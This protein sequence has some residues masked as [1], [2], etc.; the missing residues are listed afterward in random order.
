MAS[1]V[2]N[3][4]I[5]DLVYCGNCG[6]H[7]PVFHDLAPPEQAIVDEWLRR[8]TR[9]QDEEFCNATGLSRGHGKLFVL[10]RGK[11]VQAKGT[12]NSTPCPHCTRWLQGP[13]AQQCLHCSADWH[14][15]PPPLN[16]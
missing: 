16:E 7:V 15:S 4:W 8:G 14:E 10:H 9:L 5:Y 1:K 3:R 13:R 11:P 12:L 6:V 2:R